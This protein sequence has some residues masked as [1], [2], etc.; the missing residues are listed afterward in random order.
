M[1]NNKIGTIFNPCCQ[2]PANC[3]IIIIYNYLLLL[4]RN[5]SVIT[6]VTT[7]LRTTDNNTCYDA[8]LLDG[9]TEAQDVMTLDKQDQVKMTRR[10]VYGTCTVSRR[11]TFWSV[12]CGSPAAVDQ[13]SSALQP[14]RLQQRTKTSAPLCTHVHTCMLRL[15]WNYCEKTRLY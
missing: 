4:I 1:K 14:V 12:D 11:G 6:S 7:T 3:H 13:L 9:I 10:Q 8:E 15:F 5:N 2:R